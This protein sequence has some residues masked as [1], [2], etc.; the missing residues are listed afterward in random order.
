[1]VL[2]F[3]DFADVSEVDLVRTVSRPLMYGA[4]QH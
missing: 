2:G 1:M 4:S 3:M